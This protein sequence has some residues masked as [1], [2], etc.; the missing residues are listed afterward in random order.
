MFTNFN[1]TLFN[2]KIKN[3]F[4]CNILKPKIGNGN[5]IAMISKWKTITG[6][7]WKSNKRCVFGLKN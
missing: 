1:K 3:T 7:L 6:L 5:I 4:V 2:S